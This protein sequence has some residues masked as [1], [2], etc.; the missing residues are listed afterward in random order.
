MNVMDL[1]VNNL[2]KNVKESLI[3]WCK[4]VCVC[5]WY[6]CVFRVCIDVGMFLPLMYM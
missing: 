2:V 6:I 1:N 5:V 4:Y 3:L